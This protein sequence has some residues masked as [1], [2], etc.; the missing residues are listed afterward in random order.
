MAL[1]HCPEGQWKQ[2]RLHLQWEVES[3]CAAGPCVPLCLGLAWQILSRLNHPLPKPMRAKLVAAADG[4]WRE[5]SSPWGLI[6][7]TWGEGEGGPHGC[8]HL[9]CNCCP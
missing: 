9:D 8:R 4:H 7:V 2:A 1:S 3:G 6:T 5:G